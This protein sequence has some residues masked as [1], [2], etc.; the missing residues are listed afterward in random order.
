MLAVRRHG[1]RWWPW[2]RK[3]HDGADVM[4]NLREQ[5]LTVSAEELKIV[6]SSTRPNVFGILMETGYSKGVAS[7]VTFT[8]GTTSLYF[9]GGGGIIGAGQHATVRSTL[10]TLFDI[11]EEHLGEFVVAASTPLPNVGEVRFY[12]R[13]FKGLVAAESS[14]DDLGFGR[15]QLSRLFHAGHATIAAVREVDEGHGAA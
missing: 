15:H 4:R 1:I 3:K 7:L 13:T 14:E 8:D 12:L 2:R 11:A 9:S 5:A 6:P 10:E